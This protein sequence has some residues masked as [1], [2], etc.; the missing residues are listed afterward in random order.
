MRNHQAADHREAE[1]AAGFGAGAP[2]EGDRQRAGERR[3]RRHHDRAEAHDAGLVDRLL[4]RLAMGAPRIES[5]IDHHDRVFLHN[6][7][8]Q[9]N[10][11]ERNEREILVGEQQGQQRT[12]SGRG[13][14]RENRDGM[15]VTFIKHAQDNVDDDD[16]REN[17]KGFAF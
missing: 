3:E 12:H 13:Q 16:G 5:E 4:R 6:A 7:D 14:A 9:N 8:Q 17:Q 1:R 10:A 2:A 15:N 11:D